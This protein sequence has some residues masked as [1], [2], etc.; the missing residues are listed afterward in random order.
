[1]V[2][3]SRLATSDM[4]K[5]TV[6]ILGLAT[7]LARTKS[8]PALCPNRHPAVAKVP[9]D[10]ALEEMA[11]RDG[12]AKLMSPPVAAASGSVASGDSAFSLPG[13]SQSSA[14]T[15]SSSELSTAHS[16][17]GA[18]AT[19][20][21]GSGLAPMLKQLRRRSELRKMLVQEY[22]EKQEV[23]KFRRLKKEYRSSILF[24]GETLAWLKRHAPR[25]Y[26]RQKQKAD[27]RHDAKSW[28]DS[29]DFDGSGEISAN[30]LKQPLK[31]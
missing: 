24:Q 26:K 14:Y 31:L 22:E 15:P 21:S 19:A 29:L 6:K 7:R 17:P 11:E 20:G 2:I 10:P 3:V 9:P 18:D 23:A 4:N 28:F 1:M 27:R 13:L 5:W 25:R 12:P 8:A 16:I 30:E